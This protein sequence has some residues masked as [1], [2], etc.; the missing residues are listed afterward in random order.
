M[1]DGRAAWLGCAVREIRTT[2]KTREKKHRFIIIF[3]HCNEARE[4][5]PVKEK[6]KSPSLSYRGSCCVITCGEMPCAWVP[7][8]ALLVCALQT[9]SFSLPF[10][11]LLPCISPPLYFEIVCIDRVIIRNFSC[12][13]NSFFLFLI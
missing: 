12:S 4:N 9:I 5:N 13:E 11:S 10:F 2:T 8:Y 6:T 7:L 1:V 3:P